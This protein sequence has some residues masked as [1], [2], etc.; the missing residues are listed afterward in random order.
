MDS[1]CW[2]SV[3]EH[4]I[5]PAHWERSRKFNVKQIQYI[6]DNPFGFSIRE[7]L[8]VVLRISQHFIS[9]S[10]DLLWKRISNVLEWSVTAK[11]CV[12]RALVYL[13]LFWN[14]G[15]KITSARLPL[16]RTSHFH[17]HSSSAYPSLWNVTHIAKRKDLIFYFGL[18]EIAHRVHIPY[19]F[20]DNIWDIWNEKERIIHT[21]FKADIHQCSPEK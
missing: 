17:R 2:R 20:Y 12:Q 21:S 13:L 18:P 4:Q 7:I 19:W 15:V 1:V 14:V 11:E 5:P 10:G 6:F 16:G 8:C 9:M 3:R